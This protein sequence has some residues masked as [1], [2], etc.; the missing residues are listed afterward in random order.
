[1][2]HLYAALAEKE[3][4]LISQRTRSALAAK[5]AQGVKLGDPRAAAAA[6]KAHVAI[7]AADQFAANVLPIV[8]EIQAFGLTKLRDIAGAL[9]ARGIRIARGGAWYRSTVPEPA[10]AKGLARLR[11]RPTRHVAAHTKFDTFASSLA[12]QAKLAGIRPGDA[13]AASRIAI[14]WIHRRFVHEQSELDCA[15][16]W[17]DGAPDHAIPAWA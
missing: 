17:S 11:L 7:E 9:N 12:T 3:R 5:K 15:S 6:A 2:L 13:I 10:A 16:K 8:R 4:S 14:A 1:M